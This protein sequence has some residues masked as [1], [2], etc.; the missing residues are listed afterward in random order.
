MVLTVLF[1]P[2]SLPERTATEDVLA[3]V[4]SGM[5]SAARAARFA[6]RSSLVRNAPSR[7]G[8]P[9]PGKTH[10]PAEKDQIAF[11]RSVIRTDTRQNPAI[12][13]TNQAIEIVRERVARFAARF[14]LVR[15]APS[16]SGVPA[17]HITFF[18]SVICTDTRRNVAI[19]DTNQGD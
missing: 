17:D 13:R 14:S 1:V 5:G 4:C 18:R 16:K 19:C 11:F 6:A 8:V 10:K 12:C 15:N 2:N 7:S 9:A 3:D